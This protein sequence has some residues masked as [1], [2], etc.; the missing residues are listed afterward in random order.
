MS[1]P[2]RFPVFIKIVFAIF[3]VACTSLTAKA[4]DP[5]IDT[6]DDVYVFVTNTNATVLEIF[7]LVEK[8][9]SFSFVYDENDINISKEIKLAKGQQL[10]EEVLNNISKQAG[11]HFTEKQNIILVN[12]GSG[13]IK[14][15]E[16][17]ITATPVTGIVTDASG[18]PLEAITISVKGSRVAVQTDAQ[19]KFSIDVP[20]NGVL[21]FSSVNY[22]TQEVSVN[23]QSSLNIKM[24]A[25]NK[26]LNEV[27]VVGYQ[28]QKRS[29]ITGAVT[30]VNVD[31][32]S[33][34]PIGFADQALQGQAS[35][36]R[37]TQSTGQPGDGVAIRV[38]GVGSINN[39]DPLYIIDGVPTQDGI[40]FL[41]ADDIASITVLKDAA[42]AAI[43]G[44]RSSNGVVVITTKNGK[45][46]KP[47]ISYS[48][49]TGVQT[50][51]YL[52]PMATA[53]EYKT[54]FNEMVANDNVGLSPGNPLIK[55]P[56]PDSISMANTDW[57]GSIF[58][59]APEQDHELSVSG[60]NEKTQYSISGNY[61]K[62]DGIVLNSWYNRYTL[63][64]K[65]T[66]E[67]TEKLKIGTTL[68]FSYYDK[69]SI[70]SSGDGLAGNG[71]SVVRYAL[72]RDPAIPIYTSPERV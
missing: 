19:G 63:R 20:G 4:Y 52:T 9:T 64:T 57:I 33:K 29:N 27:V 54:I 28:T 10:L 62:Q 71:G 50:H 12:E 8:Q 66:T 68:S 59:V 72:F 42:S 15:A 58:R 38:R 45:S 11:L 47:S 60:G 7:N 70:G 25:T 21:I 43:Y 24:I 65:L 26:E 2:Q 49:Y 6:F 53:S 17:K 56:I 22:K 35:G 23:G 3:I 18:T 36:V 51:G 46:G 44:A 37:V 30:T 55:K 32:I 34:I 48:V 67:L 39:N 61:F 14:N 69:N 41:A 5:R 40:N 31:N 1:T 16:F 13:I